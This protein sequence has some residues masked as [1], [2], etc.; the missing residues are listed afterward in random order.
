M[1]I[2]SVADLRNQLRKK[3]IAPVYTLFGAETFLRDLAAKTIA[4]FTLGETSLREFNDTVFDLDETDVQ[5]ALASAEQLPMMAER[6]VI[7]ITNVKIAASSNRDNLKEEHEN[8]LAHYLS[9]PSETSVVIFI[10][11][12]IDKR[13]KISKLL[14]ENSVAVEFKLMEDF[15]LVKW[16]KEKFNEFGATADEKALRYL[17]GL[18][19]ANLRKLNVEIEKLATAALPDKLITYE[20]VKE[21][22]PNTKEMSNFVLTDNLLEKNKSRT[23]QDLKKILDDGAEPLMILGLLAH[24]YRRLFASKELM[25]QGVDRREVAKVMR[26]PYGRQEEFLAEARRTEPE[27]FSKILVRL[28]D[29]DLAIKTSRATPRLQIEM[30]FCELL[31]M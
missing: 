22:I 7:Q 15:E 25:N 13:R 30:L 12:E 9:N 3:E 31:E 27:K 26:L 8:L 17:V 18:V 2:L 23:L 19:G 20:L 5:Y 28:A 6:R 10:G 4:D 1:K 16:V 11:D 14:L 24:H 29:T 21:L